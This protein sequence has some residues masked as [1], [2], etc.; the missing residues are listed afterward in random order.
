MADRIMCRQ[1]VLV[2]DVPEEIIVD[3]LVSLFNMQVMEMALEEKMLADWTWHA[4]DSVRTI[5][6]IRIYGNNPWGVEEQPVKPMGDPIEQLDLTVR[7]YNVLKRHGIHTVSELCDMT[8]DQ[9][10]DLEVGGRLVVESVR[11]QL[12]ERGLHLKGE[13]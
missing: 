12:A 9:V 6:P 4:S 7:A 8:A 10:H 3:Q 13:S 11:K 2:M 1:V 5:E